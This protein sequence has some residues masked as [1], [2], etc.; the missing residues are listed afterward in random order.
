MQEAIEYTFGDLLK[1]SLTLI[2]NLIDH[3]IVDKKVKRVRMFITRNAVKIERAKVDDK[4]RIEIARK[5]R[6]EAKR[7]AKI[8]AKEEEDTSENSPRGS[9]SAYSPNDT[10]NEDSDS[11]MTESVLEHSLDGSKS[12]KLSN[13]G[14][15]SPSSRGATQ[16]AKVISDLLESQR[17]LP[18]ECDEGSAVRG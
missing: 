5:I 16:R 10:K 13:S 7:L 1:P 15:P 8:K 9:R 14:S 18:E 2:D 3:S 17:R 4:E 11:E 6:H 12:K